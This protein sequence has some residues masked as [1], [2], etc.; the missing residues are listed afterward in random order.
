MRPAQLKAARQAAG[1]TQQEAA[2]RLGVSQPYYS[3]LE[4]GSRPMRDDLAL[5]AVRKLRLS[6]TTLP[7]PALSQS[8]TPVP[9]DELASALAWLGYPGFTHLRKTASPVN[10]AELVARALAHDDLEPRLVEA[11]PWVLATFYDLDWQWLVAQCRL[12]DLQNRLGFLVSLADQLAK[13]GASEHLRAALVDLERSRLA[14]EG[15]VCRDKMSDAE[16]NW[17]RKQR[18]SDAAHWNLLTTL[19]ADQLTHA[20]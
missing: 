18:S 4:K 17:M 5:T 20:A 3:Q 10:P 1:W 2:S 9:P 15:T 12:L 7:L 8:V 6:P 19:T 13:P 14:S 11:L 16:R